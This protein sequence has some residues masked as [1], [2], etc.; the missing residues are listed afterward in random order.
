MKRLAAALL[1]GLVLPVAGRGAPH[2]FPRPPGIDAAVRFWTRVYTQVSTDGGLLHDRDNLGIVYETV[3]LRDR[4][5][6]QRQ[7]YIRQRKQHYREVLEAIVD[8]PRKRLT[9][10]EERVLALWPEGVRDQRLREAAD[11]IRFQLGQSDKFRAGLVRSGAWEPHIRRTLERLGLPRELAALPHVESSFRPDA[12]SHVGAAGLWQFT[13]ATG[14]R[15]MRIDHVVDERMDPFRATLA[16]AQLLQ[17]NY[18]VTD[19]W[20]L[21]ITAYNHGLSGMRRATRQLGTKNIATFIDEYQGRAWG[22][23]SRNF[24]AAFLAAVEVDFHAERYF[25]ALERADELVSETVEMPCFAP[26]EALVD[27]FDVARSRLRALNGALRE[28]VWSGDKRVPEGFELRVPVGPK[29]PAAQALDERIP[30]EACYSAQ[31]PDRFHEVRRGQTLSTIAA[32]YDTSARKLVSLNNLPSRDLIRAGQ[33]LRLPGAPAPA[34]D[35]GTYT[36]RRGDTLSG[37]ASRVDMSPTRLARANDLG[38]SDRIFPGQKLRI[39]AAAEDKAGPSAPES[40]ATYT[41]DRGDTLNAIARRVGMEPQRLARANDLADADRIYPGQQ[42]TIRGDTAATTAGASADG[43]DSTASRSADATEGAN[44]AEAQSASTTATGS[45]DAEPSPEAATRQRFVLGGYDAPQ[46][47]DSDVVDPSDTA[48]GESEAPVETQASLSADPADY[49]VADDATIEVQAAETLGHYAEWLDLRA[50]E[51][52]RINDLRFGKTLVVG[53]RLELAFRRVSP[54]TFEER[55]L[56]YHE[57][58]Q[59]RFFEQFRITGTERE[60]I[61]AGDSLWSIAGRADNVPV[62]LLR[63]YN[64]DLDFNDLHPGMPVILPN[65]ERQKSEPDSAST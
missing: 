11:D 6:R 45:D 14:R 26:I 34:G 51:L 65:L 9:P 42:L 40:K 20:A 1:V 12:W 38:D 16:A 37:I 47:P 50:S 24:Y 25:G 43:A 22:F 44:A 56:A 4:S 59:A 32:R 8:K 2:D 17:H 48:A 7:R 54:A 64:P 41:V 55:R 61:R 21:A 63:Q 36:V 15:Y 62:W 5:R 18:A 13:R 39:D 10:A 29:R 52:R 60:V 57:Q 23:A 3:R 58:L 19:N 49:A 46:A 33:T 28:P 31:V 30:G 27:A 53:T 35:D